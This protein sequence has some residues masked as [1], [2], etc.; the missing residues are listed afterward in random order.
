M[1]VEKENIATA[2]GRKETERERDVLASS[3][4][5]K[6]ADTPGASRRPL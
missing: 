2:E 3:S 6:L 5:F 1:T 4:G